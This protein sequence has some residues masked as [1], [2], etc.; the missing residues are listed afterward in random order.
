MQ[1]HDVR[2]FVARRAEDALP[3]LRRRA[4]RA[5]RVSER[6]S[7]VAQGHELGPALLA[8]LQMAL[9]GHPLV[10]VDRVERVGS[11]EVVRFG[12]LKWHVIGCV[13]A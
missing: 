12:L 13:R 2:A 5:G 3:Q 9:E 1:R 7:R 10:I 6:G 11:D 4:Y 8:G